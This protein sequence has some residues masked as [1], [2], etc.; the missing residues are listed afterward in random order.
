MSSFLLCATPVYGHVAPM[1]TIGRHL[2]DA[3]HHVRMLTGG[4][5]A[6]AVTAA[7]IEH[8]ALPEAADYDDRDVAGAF[9]GGE[10]LTGVRRIRFDVENNFVAVMPH[11]Y[12]G[13]RS[14]MSRGPVDAVL[15]ETAFTGVIPLLLEDDGSRPPVLICG[16]LPLPLS[17]RDTAPFGLGLPPSSTPLGRLRNRSLN[18]L[19]SRV[20]F[21]RAQRLAQSHLR[22]L[23]VAP[24]PCFVLDFSSLSDG[25]LQLTG[26][27]FEYPRSDL[28]TAV[29]YVGAVLPTVDAFE[30]PSWWGELDGGRAVVLVTQGTIANGDPEALLKPTIRALADDDVLVVA[31]TGDEVT[32]HA[33]RIQSPGNARV[34]A[35]LPY[36]RLL[37]KVD[38]MVTNGG[39][40]GVQFALANG[41][42]LVVAGDTE[43]KP[44]IAARVAW[45]GAGINLRT[46]RPS[47]EAVGGAVHRILGE[48]GYRSSAERMRDE[49][50]A[51]NPP[52]AIRTA[53]EKAV[54]AAHA[55]AGGGQD[56]VG[57]R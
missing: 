32:A 4:R 43:D 52:A 21:G 47:Q 7:G 6:D 24:L 54:P 57:C 39:Y 26:P 34:E 49:L 45:A 41:V 55:T 28:R 56:Q 44:E 14:A 1:I 35:F 22:D 9:P 53:L 31:T 3:G 48:A 50:A 8:L 30:P 16:V 36:D 5:F 38:V 29:E 10:D 12:L 25:I 46:G 23:G 51:R 27:G 17:S 20:I 42:P 2:V 18:K 11:Q 33:L 37:P 40:G 19:V 15:S 13:I